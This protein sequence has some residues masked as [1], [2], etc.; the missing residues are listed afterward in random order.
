MSRGVIGESGLQELLDFGREFSREVGMAPRK[1]WLGVWEPSGY[2]LVMEIARRVY[3]SYGFSPSGCGTIAAFGL[4]QN[5]MT[6][7]SITG[8][9]RGSRWESK[10][11]AWLRLQ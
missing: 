1:V 5:A 3:R 7:G 8:P 2:T 9:D 11:G 10:A 4:S 6:H